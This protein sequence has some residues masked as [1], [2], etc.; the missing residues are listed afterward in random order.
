MNDIQKKIKNNNDDFLVSIANKT[1]E[2]IFS[3]F[4]TSK[5]GLTEENYKNNCANYG[6]NVLHTKK[7]TNVFKVLLNATITPFNMLML[8][9][10]LLNI[11]IPNQQN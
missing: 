11:V 10:A 1:E 9:M 7:N 8:A 3:N 2:E 4:V 6:T 5:N